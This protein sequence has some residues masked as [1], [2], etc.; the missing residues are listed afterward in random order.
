[1]HP[2]RNPKRP[3]IIAG[4]VASLFLTLAP[5]TQAQQ[6]DVANPDVIAGLYGTPY[7]VKNDTGQWAIP[8]KIFS[9][10]K[11]EIFIPDIAGPTWVNWHVQKA[12]TRGI[13]YF[14]YVYTYKKEKRTTSLPE[15]IY[16]NTLRPNRVLVR[17][18]FSQRVIDPEKS[19]LLDRVVKRITKLV[20]GEVA[21]Q[22][23]R[24]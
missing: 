12:G 1:M 20:E 17:T 10:S 24:Q 14:L 8:M 16:V 11:V 7:R 2:T 5:F 18:M 23:L 4:L 15:L 13:A 19:P 21:R 3:K 6:R 9:N 22:G